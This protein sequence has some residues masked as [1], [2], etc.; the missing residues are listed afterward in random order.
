MG[1]EGDAFCDEKAVFGG[2]RH[3]ISENVYMYHSYT[4]RICFA[5][6]ILWPHIT[7]PP[8]FE[9]CGASPSAEPT[10]ILPKGV[11]LVIDGGMN[12]SE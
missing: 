5:E 7:K 12:I 10:G 2:K 11:C 4:C 6:G 9:V 8:F 1:Q 3:Y